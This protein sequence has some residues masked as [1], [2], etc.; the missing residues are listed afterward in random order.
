MNNFDLNTPYAPF[1]EMWAFKIILMLSP[2]S[3]SQSPPGT[4]DSGKIRQ[5]VRKH[6]QE[7]SSTSMEDDLLGQRIQKVI[8][9]V[10]A[11]HLSCPDFRFFVTDF[12]ERPGSWEITFL[13]VGALYGGVC[14]YGSFRQG[15]EYVY[16]DLKT[17]F[18]G[19]KGLNAKV[20]KKFKDRHIM[21]L[22][23]NKPIVKS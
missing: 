8:L 18:G 20:R 17:L 9:E 23:L 6:L 3:P 5:L 12:E 11:D 22:D 2:D 21:T 15:L 1:L 10:V 13:V 19:I 7:V 14:G 4:P 16:S